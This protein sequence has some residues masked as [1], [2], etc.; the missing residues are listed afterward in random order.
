MKLEE[1]FTDEHG[2]KWIEIECAPEEG[3]ATIWADDSM[4]LVGVELDITTLGRL[5]GF[6]SLCLEA[7]RRMEELK[8]DADCPVCEGTGYLSQKGDD[9]CPA[10]ACGR[11]KQPPIK[12]QQDG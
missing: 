2:T 3:R 6:L 10:C 9:T 7:I 5:N 4:E 1:K 11:S 8:K 12:E